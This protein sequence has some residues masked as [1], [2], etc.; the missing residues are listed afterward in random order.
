VEQLA[1]RLGW[2]SDA[3]TS[4]PKLDSPRKTTPEELQRVAAYLAATDGRLND[5]LPTMKAWS[6]P[7]ATNAT[8]AGKA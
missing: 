2:S 4:T 8:R 5:S 1:E 6:L 3:M 7:T